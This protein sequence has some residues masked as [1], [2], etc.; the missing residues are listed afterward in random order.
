MGHNIDRNPLLRQMDSRKLLKKAS[1]GDQRCRP[2]N[3]QVNQINNDMPP[4]FVMF[5]LQV[6]RFLVATLQSTQL[7]LLHMQQ[8]RL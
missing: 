6:L 3:Y 5:I 4:Y 1:Q 2:T 7:K 8:E